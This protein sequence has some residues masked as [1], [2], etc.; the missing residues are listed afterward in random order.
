LD[1]FVTQLVSTLGHWL[2]QAGRSHWGVHWGLS[3]TEVQGR[4]IGRELPD[5]FG[6]AFNDSVLVGWLTRKALDISLAFIAH[7]SEEF[8][9]ELIS[10]NLIII[11]IDCVDTLIN[12]SFDCSVDL[13]SIL[14]KVVRNAFHTVGEPSGFQFFLVAD[15]VEIVVFRKIFLNALHEF[16]SGKTHEC[17]EHVIV[18]SNESYSSEGIDGEEV[19]EMRSKN[20][21]G[22]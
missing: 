22:G 17:I 8:A 3:L 21:P 13:L 12:I 11:L 16:G 5:Y 7:L 14:L 19:K 2:L 20:K 1:I 6:E 9:K 10:V 18:F 15:A 4:V